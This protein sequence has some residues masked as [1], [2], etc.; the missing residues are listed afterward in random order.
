MSREPAGID[1]GC[2]PPTSEW[3]ARVTAYPQVCSS[4][5]SRDTI[6]MSGRWLPPENGS[7]STNTSR[8][9]G[10]RSITAATASGIAPRCTGMCSAWATIR[11][12]AS[13][14]AAEQSRRS[15]MFEEYALRTSAVPI[16]S[17]TPDSALVSTDS[18]IGSRRLPPALVRPA[19]RPAVTAGSPHTG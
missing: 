18:V 7:L 6:V 1:P 11:P 2:I 17:A 8:G 12:R 10:S 19:G 3:C 14:S 15:L 13:N 9:P 16:S 5:P 4:V